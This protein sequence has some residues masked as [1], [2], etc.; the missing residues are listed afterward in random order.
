MITKSL[1]INKPSRFTAIRFFQKGQLLNE[2]K[3]TGVLHIYTI[4]CRV[5]LCDLPI[6]N[7]TFEDSIYFYI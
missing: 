4:D 1:V 2:T 3:T 6:F 7:K 5:Y